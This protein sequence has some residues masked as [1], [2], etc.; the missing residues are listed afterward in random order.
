MCFKRLQLII[1]S[2]LQ[3]SLSLLS[4]FSLTQSRTEQVCL[5][6]VHSSIKLFSPIAASPN[7]Q[8]PHVSHTFPI[9]SMFLAKTLPSRGHLSVFQDLPS[10][11]GVSVEVQRQPLTSRSSMLREGSKLI[12]SAFVPLDQK[13]WQYFLICGI[14]S[15]LEAN[16][17]VG[18]KS[19]INRAK[20]AAVMKFY[21]LQLLFIAFLQARNLCSITM[22]QSVIQHPSSVILALSCD[23]LPTS[24]FLSS[25]ILMAVIYSPHF[26]MISF[27]SF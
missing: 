16:M 9:V 25:S 17:P 4:I 12:L 22:A 11:S 7:L 3:T 27:N 15:G 8:S 24:R 10:Q 18:S 23:P 5:N 13:T 6:F 26:L 2:T 14:V 20:A 21:I 19:S 1:S